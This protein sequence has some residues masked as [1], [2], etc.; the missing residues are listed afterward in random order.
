M[1]HAVP[2]V[3]V[4]LHRHLVTWLLDLGLPGQVDRVQEP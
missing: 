2:F 1:S 3:Q 4:S